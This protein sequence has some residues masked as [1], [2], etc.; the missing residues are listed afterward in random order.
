MSDQTS[1]QHFF[2]VQLNWLTDTK[3]QLTA[4]DAEGTIHVATP[5][6][7]GGS[8]KPWT[9]EHLCLGAISSCY[10]STYLSIAKKMKFE[11]SHLSCNA[12]GKLE[13]VDGKFKF[14][15][16]NLYPKIFIGDTWLKEKANLAA[17]KTQKHCLI[18][19]S[20]SSDVF[21]HTEMVVVPENEKIENDIYEHSI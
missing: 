1:K 8:G 11:I 13:I 10:M 19:N 18:T 5:P 4:K 17:E 2:D 16:V 21:Y 14:T 12:I 9:P 7:F 20:V 3:G 15:T 6:E